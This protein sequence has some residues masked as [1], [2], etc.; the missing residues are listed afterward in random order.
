MKWVEAQI[1]TTSE[2]C[3]AIYEKLVELG[4]DGISTEDPLDIARI[5]NDPDSLSYADP[6][7]I[8][9]LGN[10][11]IVKGYFS[12]GKDFSYQKRELE[13]KIKNELNHVGKF[14]DISP[15]ELSWKFI[16]ENQWINGWKKYYHPFKISEHI[17]IVPSWEEYF[18][19]EGEKT[20]L[21]D[22][23]SA[24]GTGSHATTAM[25][26][27]MLDDILFQNEKK[28]KILDLGCGSGILSIISAKLSYSQI[29]AMDIDP[30][31]VKTA[32]DNCA[33]N[34][35]EKFIKVSCGEITDIS[36]KKYDIIVANIIADVIL[37]IAKYIPLKLND[38][39]IFIA[40]GIILDRKIE[41]LNAYKDSGLRLVDEVIENDWVTL[42]FQK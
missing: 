10:I 40:G 9:S 21:L 32:K 17:V 20:V 28:Q 1:K 16:D 37:S 33:M 29:D 5:I 27:R 19:L 2:A 12:L 30:I 14:L 24:F 18:P 41:I 11:A 13:K 7:Y 42:K 36:T 22:S 6:G 38:K 35:V 34:K 3:D 39:G 25:C 31:A 8:K 4:A 15:G 26:A 23:G